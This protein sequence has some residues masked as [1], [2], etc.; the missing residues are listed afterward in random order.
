MKPI[1][2]KLTTALVALLL[3]AMMILCAG[4]NSFGGIYR[5]ITQEEYK[6]LPPYFDWPEDHYELTYTLESFD[7]KL[8][9]GIKSLNINYL[10]KS[11]KLT[12]DPN[13]SVV[14]YAVDEH[15]VV[16]LTTTDAKYTAEYWYL[17]SDLNNEKQYMYAQLTSGDD[18]VQVKFRS[19]QLSEWYYGFLDEKWYDAWTMCSNCVY[20]IARKQLDN[21]H[22]HIYLATNTATPEK[23]IGKSGNNYKITWSNNDTLEYYYFTFD[24]SL[25]TKARQESVGIDGKIISEIK[26]SNQSVQLPSWA[27]DLKSDDER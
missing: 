9:N 3:C 21:F 7:T 19:Y 22:Y 16:E 14:E 25:V 24:G 17:T 18:L 10:L 12:T 27:K 23:P 26:Q 4:C 2:Q 20:Q 13:A 15:I 8:T 6:N 1:S 11:T 5:D